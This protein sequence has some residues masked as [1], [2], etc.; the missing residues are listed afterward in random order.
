MILDEMIADFGDPADYEWN[1]PAFEA[2][3]TDDW[4]VDQILAPTLRQQI[5]ALSGR[6]DV[7]SY[8]TE[9][10]TQLRAQMEA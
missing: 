6:L 3:P 8:T 5:A 1:A 9:H 4:S 7:T 2:W 10:A